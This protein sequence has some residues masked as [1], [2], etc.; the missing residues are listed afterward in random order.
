MKNIFYFAL[1]CLFSCQNMFAQ[2]LLM[3]G[4]YWDYPK[5]SQGYLWADT[6]K[7]KAMDMSNA[8]FTYV[9]L[10]P[11]SRASSVPNN[12]SNGYDIKDLFDLG[13]FGLGATGFGTRQN[14][15]QTIATFNAWNLKTTADVIYN[16]R[17]GGKAE[18]NPAV[19]GWIE[20]YPG[21]ASN[22][23][24]PSDRFRCY[25]PIG[26]NT[27][28]AAGNYYVKLSSKSGDAAF[29]GKTY[30]L[31]C[32]TNKASATLPYNG[33][34][35]EDE[36]NGG[37]GNGGGDCAQ[38]SN[39]L[40]INTDMI[41]T[42]DA[43]GCTVDEFKITIG[44]SN[45]Y[46]TDT[47][48]FY[49]TNTNGNYSDHRVYGIWNGTADVVNQLK[50]Q[51]Y[52][53]YAN[54][55]SGR[56]Y[57]NYTNFRPNGNPTTMCGDL[58]FPYFFYDYDHNIP[59]TRDTLTNYT[60]WMWQ[61]VGIRG[62]RMDAVKHFEPSFVSHLLNQMNAAGQNPGLV[63]GESISSTTQINDWINAVYSGMTPAA[64]AAINVRAFDFPLRW[65][66]KSA[67]DQFGY[68]VRQ[69]F[70]EGLKNASNQSSFNVVTFV[71]NH[72]FRTSDD[73]VQSDPMLAYAYIL[74]NNQIGLPTVF[75][76][77]YYGNNLSYM[78][79]A[80]L[81]NQIDELWNVH[82]QYIYGSTA[83]DYLSRFDTP[84]GQNFLGGYANTTLMY[85]MYNTP[86][87]NDV[88]VAIN[89]S[90]ET[91]RLDQTV[92]TGTGGLATGDTLVDVLGR[93]NFP[94]AV[95]NGSNQMYV[96]LPPRSYSVWVRCN[97]PS[98]PDCIA[99]PAARFK[100]KVLLQ[101]AYQPALNAMSTALKTNSLLPLQ[102][103][104]NT[105]PTNYN[106]TES[107][108]EAR[109][110]PPNTTD[111]VLVEARRT[112]DTSVISRQAAFLRADGTLLDKYG[113]EGINLPNLNNGQN[114]FIAI[115]HR[116]HLSILSNNPISLPNV[117]PF[118]FTQLNNIEGGA[119][120]SIQIA[121]NIYA[122]PAADAAT[123]GIIN[124]AD[125]NQ[126]AQQLG[127]NTYNRADLNL[128]GIVNTNDF[129]LYQ[130]NAG[131]L[132]LRILR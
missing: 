39:T 9:W 117:T 43:S 81:K 27:G 6:V 67:C 20:N 132:A 33:T 78:P 103:P 119:T 76:P 31:Y 66:L 121:P 101:G 109:V 56:G 80:S 123:N 41:V 86:T 8:A 99:A 36:N 127:N 124:Y 98:A 1:F 85:Q 112:T 74:T 28:N 64:S 3:Q 50:Y 25:L 114:Y 51:T 61:N 83:I 89:F 75:Y 54:L 100:G 49:L 17:D 34:Q 4:W 68:D 131:R 12:S 96:E 63:V 92:N 77:D 106:G 13:E 57:M 130:Q 32:T 26:G 60:K 120:Q 79:N 18:D 21:P 71:N 24:Y 42:I 16:H 23:P 93:S 44:S 35:N 47:L 65:S 69:V 87:G 125:Y 29:Y 94:Y 58:D 73:A 113:R 62:F 82:R 37:S 46:A 95:V 48:W 108:Y 84:Y 7:N 111:W 126:Y 118:D 59:S 15:N 105:A 40:P 70:N 55:A 19:E 102:Q 91:L 128:D 116:N 107:V 11:L 10:P 45:A 52:S 14:L 72:D 129:S 53:N 110:L 88:V 2:D 5:T 104:Y 22:C 30:K 90:G 122:L 38:G 115:K 97:N